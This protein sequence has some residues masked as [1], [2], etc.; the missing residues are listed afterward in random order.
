MPQPAKQCMQRRAITADTDGEAGGGVAVRRALPHGPATAGANSA[1][2]ILDP[3]G[4]ARFLLLS[5]LS[6]I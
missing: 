4:C 3:E 6:L 1:K 5:T 2:E